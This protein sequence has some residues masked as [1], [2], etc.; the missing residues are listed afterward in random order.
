MTTKYN[1][2]HI[3]AAEEVMNFA[4]ATGNEKF[5]EMIKDFFDIKEKPIYD[6]S[7]S[8]F[9]NMSQKYNI[10]MN[11]QGYKTVE[12]VRYPYY[13]VEGDI[14]EFEK[15]HDEVKQMRINVSTE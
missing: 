10:G 11:V 6:D 5:A 7:S 9:K 14:R 8:V 15:L 2:D 4:R 12:G 1:Q 13:S 3:D